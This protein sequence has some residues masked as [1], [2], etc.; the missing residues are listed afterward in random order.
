VVS[1]VHG[2]GIVTH[3]AGNI[4]FI[5]HVVE[6][7]VLGLAFTLMMSL[8]AF[9]RAV[10][11]FVYG[12][13]YEHFDGFAVFRLATVFVFCGFLWV[14]KSKCLKEVENEMASTP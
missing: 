2:I 13:L 4:A 9:S 1:L 8:S 12:L 6:P 3:I 5:R 14:L 10:M 11:S 7:K